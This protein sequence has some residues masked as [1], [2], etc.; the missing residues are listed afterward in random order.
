MSVT[1]AC[2]RAAIPSSDRCA[3]E[4]A[5]TG[6]ASEGHKL[7]HLQPLC[8]V[9]PQANTTCPLWPQKSLTHTAR[10]CLFT[11]LL[12]SARAQR[13]SNP[14]GQGSQFQLCLL[15]RKQVSTHGLACKLREGYRW[16]LLFRYF[17]KTVL[18]QTLL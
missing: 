18:A 1:Q 4:S 12:A 9:R 3:S 11:S 5:G 10:V 2:Q 16:I 8:S 15:K 13:Q 14:G 7:G 6:G 17:V